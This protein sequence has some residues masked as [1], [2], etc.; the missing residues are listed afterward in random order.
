MTAALQEH[1]TL[2]PAILVRYETLRMAAL[3]AALPPEARSGLMLFLRRGLWGWGRILAAANLAQEPIHG[4]SF[5]Q[6]AY[7]ER[8]AVIHVFA[9]MAMNVH[10]GRTR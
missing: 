8:S 6:T 7:C 3:G 9:T 4:S 2:P 5:T 10:N 1:S